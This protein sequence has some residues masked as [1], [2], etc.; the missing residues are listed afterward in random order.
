MN[1]N[2]CMEV[3]GPKN[4]TG[5]TAEKNSYLKRHIEFVKVPSFQNSSNS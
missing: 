3:V 5:I 4:E 1:Y 2:I